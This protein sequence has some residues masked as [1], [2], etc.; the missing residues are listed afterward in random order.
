MKQ[1]FQTLAAISLLALSVFASAQTEKLPPNA[2]KPAPSIPGPLHRI[3]PSV[4]SALS[5][6]Q[7][8]DA[9][10]EYDDATIRSGTEAPRAAQG[11]PQGHK[12]LL[13]HQSTQLKLP[14][15]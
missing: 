7:P 4:E 14:P 11:L 9:I 1:V 12:A 13:D 15:M 10:I 8:V 2:P 3:D 5:A 6:G